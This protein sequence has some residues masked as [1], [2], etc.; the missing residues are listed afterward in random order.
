MAK[1]G[2]P[3]WRVDATGVPVFPCCSNDG[4][5]C[6]DCDEVA[7]GVSSSE[8]SEQQRYYTDVSVS[9]FFSLSLSFCLLSSHP[10]SSP[11]DQLVSTAE[12][13]PSPL[14]LSEQVVLSA[15]VVNETLYL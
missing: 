2:F 3:S 9:F 5:S 6:S 1:E 15:R 13:P 10:A 11:Y 14:P 8:V 12:P 4:K 7:G